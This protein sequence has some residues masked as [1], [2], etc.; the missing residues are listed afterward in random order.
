MQSCRTC[1]HRLPINYTMKLMSRTLSLDPN[2]PREAKFAL[3]RGSQNQDQ[4]MP[5]LCSRHTQELSCC[6]LSVA[7][8]PRR[9]LDSRSCTLARPPWL[10]YVK[11]TACQQL[12]SVL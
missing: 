7:A 8:A 1:M 3:K 9:M 10:V 5:C 6:E 12:D 11:V 2:Q 4:G